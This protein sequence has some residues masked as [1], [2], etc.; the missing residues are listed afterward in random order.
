VPVE[1]SDRTESSDPGYESFWGAWIHR[2]SVRDVAAVFYGMLIVILG[3]AGAL[4]AV[5]RR[6]RQLPYPLGK[7]LPTKSS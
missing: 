2:D 7:A 1:I 6:Q 4:V 5:I 3:L